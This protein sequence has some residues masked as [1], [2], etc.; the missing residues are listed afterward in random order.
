MNIHEEQ[1]PLI[2]S[3][4]NAWRHVVWCVA[5]ACLFGC[6]FVKAALFYDA[7]NKIRS[8]LSR[9]VF[10]KDLHGCNAATLLEVFTEKLFG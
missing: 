1:T 2:S 8:N 6:L 4:I 5:H 7:V 3:I 9:M 10:L